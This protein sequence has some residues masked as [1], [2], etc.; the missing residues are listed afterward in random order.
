MSD[1]TK[2]ISYLAAALKA[3]G[4]RDA[5]TRLAVQARDSGWTYEDL[6]HLTDDTLPSVRLS[7]QTN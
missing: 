6:K 3:P 4:I 5:A 7:D 2:Q 1:P